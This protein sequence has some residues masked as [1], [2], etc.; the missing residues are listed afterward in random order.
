MQP[1][2][3]IVVVTWNTLDLLKKCL[4]SLDREADMPYELFVTDNGSNDNTAEFLNNYLPQNQNCLRYEAT[5]NGKDYGFPTA[6]NQGMRKAKGEYVFLLN[7]DTEVLPQ[8]LSKLFSIAEKYPRLGVMG[9]RLIFPHG[10][11]QHCVSRLP[12]ITNIIISRLKLNKKFPN[13]KFIKR[14]S[15][16]RVAE[17]TESVVPN[18]R[19]AVFFMRS[20]A[21]KKVG[22]LDEEFFLWFDE[23][24]YCK[25]LQN[26]GL[27]VM[28]TPN[29]SVIHQSEA[30]ISTM[31]I[32]E[33]LLIYNKSLR[34]YF[35][36]HHGLAYAMAAAVIDPLCT[37]IA[38]LIYRK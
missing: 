33:R 32:W 22:L 10:G 4:E 1:K 7:P 11:N 3:S 18:I 36:K 37:A 2:I 15:E 8:T 21:V 5:L 25:R 26:A 13:N 9:A 24:D 34:R 38:M 29:V 14:N 12:S 31:N 6:A 16:V 27:D 35:R 28:Y 19:G 20:S 17:G 30:G 23:T